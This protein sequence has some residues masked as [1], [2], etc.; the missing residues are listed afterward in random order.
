[1]VTKQG[2]G[3]TS[4]KILPR[5]KIPPDVRSL[6]RSHT[7]LCINRLRGLVINPGADQSNSI[8]VAAAQILLERGWGKAIQPV[9]G[10]DGA[11]A[12]EITIRKMLKDDDDNKT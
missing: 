3:L 4:L 11:G 6:A 12:I 8:S 10:A 9:A 2:E 7:T 1:M 5:K